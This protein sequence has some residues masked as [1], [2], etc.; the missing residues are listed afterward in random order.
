MRVLPVG[1]GAL[2]IEFYA[3]QDV[4]NYYGEI[5]KRRRQGWFPSIV[6]V[7]PAERTILING[8]NDPEP[9]TNDIVSWSVP[10]D[11]SLR[12][13][14]V[15]V[16]TIYNGEDLDDVARIWDMTREEVVAT[17][18]SIDFKVAFC[19]FMPGFAYLVGLPIELAVPRRSTPR[20]VVPGGAVAL[21]GEYSGIYP[22][23]SPGGWQIIGRTDL[24]L[25][26]ENRDR[27]ALLSPG[28]RVRFCD[29]GI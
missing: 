8:V 25:W 6:D 28:M 26:D 14:L 23:S 16:P 27:V 20:T 3:Q 17:H 22:R 29:A 15:E 7:V 1:Q 9:I 2:L 12:G 24:A 11:S 5:T 21:A 18:T 19:G 4:L 10:Q 13:S